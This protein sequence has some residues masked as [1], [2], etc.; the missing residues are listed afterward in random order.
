MDE[1][2]SAALLVRVALGV[3]HGVAE[4]P[5][6]DAWTRLGELVAR[7]EPG[8]RQLIPV[9]QR[10]LLEFEASPTSPARA[11]ALMDALDQ[12]ARR[13]VQFGRDLAAWAHDAR[14]RSY[15]HD[16]G[17]DLRSASLHGSVVQ[18]GPDSL[19]TFVTYGPQAP[20]RHP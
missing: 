9:A 3:V 11:E 13:D 1:G 15:T 7:P 17:H 18:S 20:S 5:E 12:R 8:Q 6:R 14:Q 10:E 16:H 4:E 19:V 2:L